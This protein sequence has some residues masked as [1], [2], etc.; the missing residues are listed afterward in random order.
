M[1]RNLQTKYH[2]IRLNKF[3]VYNSENRAPPYGGVTS[4]RVKELI[5]LFPNVMKPFFV[6]EGATRA[7]DV[8]K[9]LRPHPPMVQ[10]NASEL[11]CGNI[12]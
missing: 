6:H 1:A 3:F 7:N 12:Y 2:S 9:M 11:V 4:G 8:V 10:M 5:S